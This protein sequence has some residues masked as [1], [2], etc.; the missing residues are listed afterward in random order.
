MVVRGWGGVNRKEQLNGCRV[1]IW[2]D[3]KVLELDNGDSCTT[4]KGIKTT[5]LHTLKW[6]KW[7]IFVMCI[8]PHKNIT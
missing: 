1:S 7:L 5:E 6:L 2:G 8:L 3:E 4:L